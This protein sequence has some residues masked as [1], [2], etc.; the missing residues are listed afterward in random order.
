MDTNTTLA[1]DTLEFYGSPKMTVFAA[2]ITSS[3]L[4]VISHQQKDT[5]TME[6]AADIATMT[7]CTHNYTGE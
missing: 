6:K 1:R 5:V 7:T 4:V 2:E 3:W